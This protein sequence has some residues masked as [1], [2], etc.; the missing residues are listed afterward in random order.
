MK[1][2]HFLLRFSIFIIL[3][4]TTNG[5]FAQ[6]CQGSLGAP[7]VN[8]TFG[9]G[10]NPGPPIAASLTNYLYVPYGC[11]ADGAYT[12]GNSSPACFGDT[13]HT[14]L[15]DHTPNDTS[16]YMMIV[17]ASFSPG[18]F[19][20][21]QVDGLCDNTT[22]EFAAWLL[23]ILK[24]SA[25]GNSGI[26][27]NVTFKIETLSGTVLQTYKTGDL[28]ASAS[29][30]WQ[31]YGLFFKTP[32][33]VNSVVIR[34]TNNAPGGC[35][36]DIVLDDITFRP[37][38][39]LVTVSINNTSTTIN[40]CVG[41]NTSYTFS[42][43]VTPAV[44]NTQYQWQISTDMGITWTDIAGAVNATY[45]RMP[46]SGVGTYQYRVAVSQGNYASIPSCSRVMSK[47][48][49]I[50]QVP[51]PVPG[52]A[53]NGPVCEDATITLKSNAASAYSWTGPL[54]FTSTQ[55]SPSI[56]N[57]ALGYNGKFYVKIT[58][59]DG[60]V[61]TDSTVVN[62]IK[63]PFVDA[64]ADANICEGASTQ[65]NGATD[66]N[67]YVWNPPLNLSN[68]QILNPITSPISNVTYVL[69]VD[70]G[71]CKKS[72]SVV[73]TVNKKPIADAG[74]DKVI[75]AGNTTTLNGSANITDASILWTPSYNISSVTDLTPQVNPVVAITYA[76]TLSSNF[77][78]GVSID[79][80]LVKVYAK[81][82]I[83]NAFTPNNDGLNDVWNIEAL[84]A[85][86]GAVINVFNRFGQMV[87]TNDGEAKPWDGK[88]KGVVQS[89]GA[90]PYIINLK[91][92]A[93]IVRGVLYLIQ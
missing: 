49:I 26:L 17:N 64:G 36:N 51:L 12:I 93:P 13:W 58:S 89:A 25:C 55:Q 20:V 82:F 31:Q 14:L 77:G 16:G 38:G 57:A 92:G 74:P 1:R 83:P 35:G 85:Y 87:F 60:C 23:N 91:N 39:A 79:S 15:E 30:T 34:M 73:V 54:N 75:I 22:Y 71:T 84:E 24:T 78:C 50:N 7:V 69:T 76:L 29:P 9:S 11:P 68:P 63:G 43:M 5:A 53:N 41:D 81:L 66:A 6:L 45:I 56:A 90:Y 86:P 67:S 18:D 21:Q 10:P 88:Y 62:I 4:V 19:Y 72:D 33:G 59:S 3:I 2:S 65:L 40:A 46:V 48:L 47:P 52:A 8:I 37:C 80:V 27:P 70:N 32:V 61:N 28:P 42:T 44:A